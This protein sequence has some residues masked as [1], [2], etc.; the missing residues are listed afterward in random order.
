MDKVFQQEAFRSIDRITRELLK[1]CEI[2]TLRRAGVRFVCVENFLDGRNNALKRVLRMIDSDLLS[3]ARGTLSEP[4]DVAFVLEGI[5]HDELNYRINFGPYMPKNLDMSLQTPPAGDS[6]VEIDRSDLF[7][8][9]DLFE[10]NISF[11]EH[12]LFRWASTKLAKALEF[13]AVCR[14]VAEAKGI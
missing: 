4:G 11:V 8:D 3:S 7:F 12:S 2:R 5:T 14:A 9:I 13:V 6:R 10:R 1:V